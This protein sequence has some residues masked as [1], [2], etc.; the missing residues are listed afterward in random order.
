MDGYGVAGASSAVEKTGSS[1]WCSGSCDGKMVDKTFVMEKEQKSL[2]ED[3]KRSMMAQRNTPNVRPRFHPPPQAPSYH[4]GGQYYQPY[5]P[6]KNFQYPAPKP[7]YTQINKLVWIYE[8]NYSIEI[9][10]EL[11]M[12]I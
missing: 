3:R 8:I 10:I 1:A 2:E 5:P 7:Q 11:S 4:P 6:R 9:V 12:S